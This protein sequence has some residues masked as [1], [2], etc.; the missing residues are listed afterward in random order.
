MNRKTLP[1]FLSALLLC[2]VVTAADDSLDEVLT[3]HYEALGGLDAWKSIESCRLNG[4]MVIPMGM[5]APFV[6]TFVRPLKT[7]LEFTLQGMTGVQVFDGEKAWAILP[8]MGSSDPQMMPDEQ[9]KLMEEQADFDGPLI[10]W[11]AKGHQVALIGKAD[12]DG[13][14]AYHLEVTLASGDIRDF[15]LDAESYLLLRLEAKAEIQGNEMEIETIFSD[16]RKVGELMMAHSIES[17]PIG[18]PSGQLLTIESIELN[19]DVEEDL[20]AM[21]EPP[22]EGEATE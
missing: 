8:F 21:P 10:D 5:E 3:S 18:A 20:F 16:Y 14:E 9:A 22:E 6:T 12:V 13:T 4:R 2:A 17:K 11:E 19:I 1:L 7:R 15:Y